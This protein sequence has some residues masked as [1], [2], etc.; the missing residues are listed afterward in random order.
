MSGRWLLA[1]GADGKVVATPPNRYGRGDPVVAGRIGSG[2]VFGTD[3]FDEG[4]LICDSPSGRYRIAER[5]DRLVFESVADS[6]VSRV[7]FFT[8]TTWISTSVTAYTGPGIPDGRW[9]RDVT[10]G[11]LNDL[12]FWP[13]AA[14][15][16]ANGF[17]DGTG[18]FVIEFAASRWV[19]LFENDQGRLEIGDQGTVVYDALGRWVQHG[20][21]AVEW[22]VRGDTLTTRNA[23]LVEGL[24]P[25]PASDADRGVLEGSWKRVR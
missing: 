5:G 24:H 20:F 12:H 25:L 8:K 13:D 14:W 1:L 16:A 21:T 19:I 18:R 17:S 3:L 9:A 23:V 4:N 10:V 6:C 22:S 11:Q 2:G 7:Q 15:K